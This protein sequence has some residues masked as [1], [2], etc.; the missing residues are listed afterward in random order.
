[1]NYIKQLNAYWKRDETNPMTLK[2]SLMYLFI[3]KEANKC[4]WKERFSV[5]NTMLINRLKISKSE[6]FRLRKKLV[7]NGL[8]Q[9]YKGSKGKAGQYTI[10]PLYD[11]AFAIE[12]A[13]YKS[14]D[15]TN[16]NTNIKTSV[17]TKVETNLET[18]MSNIHK[19][20]QKQNINAKEVAAAIATLD[21][22]SDEMKR[23]SEAWEKA[24]FGDITA[25]T[26]EELGVY[27]D[28]GMEVECILYAIEQANSNNA[29]SLSYV[30]SILKRLTTDGIKTKDDLGTKN[31]IGKPKMCH[32]YEE[33]LPEDDY[34]RLHN[35]WDEI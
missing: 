1:M 9:Y 25:M 27:L 24:G 17:D 16:N 10:I 35:S 26:I 20:K 3:L 31:H 14:G 15:V 5:P 13:K 21:E 6:V 29:R 32:K 12:D 2:L 8:V 23:I 4:G 7:S 30:R 22:I 19:R 11:E 34:F 18:E 33:E 28:D